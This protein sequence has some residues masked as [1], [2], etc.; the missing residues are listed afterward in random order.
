[1]DGTGSYTL[2]VALFEETEPLVIPGSGG[3]FLISEEFQYSLFTPEFTGTWVIKTEGGY[4]YLGVSDA[5]RSFMAVADA[6]SWHPVPFITIDLAEGFEYRI[7]T[8]VHYSQPSD[9]PTLTI[10]P[11]YQMLPIPRIMPPELQ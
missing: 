9:N 5:N 1:L 7:V 3:S 10:I 2:T 4:T 6:W 8:L 11:A